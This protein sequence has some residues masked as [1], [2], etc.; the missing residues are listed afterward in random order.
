MTFI[1]TF[2]KRCKTYEEARE[3]LDKIEG[4]GIKWEIANDS[5][6]RS[7]NSETAVAESNC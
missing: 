2:T 3:Y 4:P 7:S 1:I 6:T 5:E